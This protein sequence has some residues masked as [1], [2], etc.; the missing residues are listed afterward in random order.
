MRSETNVDVS[1]A[2]VNKEN[3]EWSVNEKGK[4]SVNEKRNEGGCFLVD[5]NKEMKWNVNEKKKWNI[6]EKSNEDGCYSCR[7][8]QKNRAKCKGKEKVKCKWRESE[9]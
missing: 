2:D 7:W 3:M 1:L 9:V 5:V 8:K 4:L 6:K